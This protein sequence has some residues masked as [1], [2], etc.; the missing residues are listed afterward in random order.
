MIFRSDVLSGDVQSL[1]TIHVIL[2]VPVPVPTSLLWISKVVV[3]NS[4]LVLLFNVISLSRC[5]VSSSSRSSHMQISAILCLSAFLSVSL[6]LIH[7]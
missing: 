7:R 5:F 3:I 6:L 2:S 1:Y 4:W